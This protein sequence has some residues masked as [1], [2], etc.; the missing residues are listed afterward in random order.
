[1]RWHSCSDRLAGDANADRDR[2]L[3]SAAISDADC[4]DGLAGLS[5]GHTDTVSIEIERIENG[6]TKRKAR[7][8][9]KAAR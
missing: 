4:Y 1:M 7:G 9:G 2:L 8:N 5:T 6:E 3:S